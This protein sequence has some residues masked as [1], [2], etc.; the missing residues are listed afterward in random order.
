M[1]DPSIYIVAINFLIGVIMM[2]SSA[3]VG[4]LAGMPFS[5]RP[6]EAARACR[7]AHISVLTLGSATAAF[8]AAI[9]VLFYLL[10][11]GV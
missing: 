3:R 2:L 6:Q 10:R 5:R 9:Y 11:I 8:M 4:E 1:E 7:I